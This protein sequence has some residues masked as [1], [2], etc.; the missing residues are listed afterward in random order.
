ML[1]SRLASPKFKFSP[2]E[3]EF[4]YEIVEVNN[5]FDA[6]FPKKAILRQLSN[7]SDETEP[8]STAQITEECI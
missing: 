5:E 2:K 8:V 3:T 7:S 1:S 6:S 4:Q